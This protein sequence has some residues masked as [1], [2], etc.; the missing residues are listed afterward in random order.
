[1]HFILSYE[2]VE[3]VVEKRAPHRKAHLEYLKQAFDAGEVV[4]GGA[5]ADPL[6]GAVLVFRGATPE[7]AERF[8]KSDPYVVNGIVTAWR[9][10]N[11]STVIGDGASFPST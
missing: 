10:R 5:L 3:D 7:A 2:Y 6:D 1:M 9:V 11:W 8:A 4:I